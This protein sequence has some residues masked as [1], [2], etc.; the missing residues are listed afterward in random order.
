MGLQYHDVVLQSS[1][2]GYAPLM[3]IYLPEHTTHSSRHISLLQGLSESEAMLRCASGQGNVAP[4]RTS[5]STLQILRENVFTSVN[6]ILFV[7]GFVLIFLGQT[8]DAMIAVSVAFFNVLVSVVQE[9]RAK[10][11]LDRIALLTRPSASVMREGHERLIDPSEI[12]MGDLLAVRPGDQV[13]VDGPV[14]ESGRLEVDESLLTGESDPV[15]KRTGDWL[16]SGSFCLSGSAYY[17]AEKACAESMANQLTTGA[18]AFRRVY[19][20]LQRQINLIIQVMLLVAMSNVDVLCLDKTGT[21]TAN[22]MTLDALSPVGIEEADLQ[23]F[24]GNYVASLSVRNVTSIAIGAAY[25]GQTLPVSEEVP[26]SSARKWSALTLDDPE[27]RG[28]YVLGAPEVL[29]P[30][31]RSGTELGALVEEGAAR[32]LR[33]VLFASIPTSSPCRIPTVSYAYQLN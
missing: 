5:R 3:T 8:S 12:V 6:T 32:G 17:G 2:A 31:L 27:Q 7:L 21:L 20:P 16:Y 24:L 14:V 30:S 13:V 19:T 28:V 10:R 26:F 25:S 23:R 9:I 11:T 15:S 1:F 4:L 29:Q 22:A 33:M 18:R